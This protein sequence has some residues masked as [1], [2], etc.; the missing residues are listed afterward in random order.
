MF[1]FRSVTLAHLLS[2]SKAACFKCDPR[3][4]KALQ[5]VQAAVQEALPLASNDLADPMILE[6]SVADRDDVWSLWEAPTG[7]LH[8]RP[9]GF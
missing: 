4:E 6:I 1:L 2:D 5:K 7:E 9:L 8:H 3:E